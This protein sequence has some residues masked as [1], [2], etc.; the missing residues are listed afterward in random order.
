MKT[1]Q[2]VDKPFEL[3]SKEANAIMIMLD[4]AMQTI[5]IDEG[6]D[7]IADWE[8]IHH[9]AAQLL[10]YQKFKEWYKDNHDE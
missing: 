10:A 9:H 7:P 1:T 8:L 3:S 2:K 6:V 5:F 4:T